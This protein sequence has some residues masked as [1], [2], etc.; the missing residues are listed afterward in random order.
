M[1][2]VSGREWTLLSEKLTPPQRLIELYGKVLAQLLVNRGFEDHHE[3]IFDIRLSAIPSYKHL[4]NIEEGAERIVRA[5]RKKERIII[6]GDYDVDGLTGTAILYEILRRAGA[7]VVPV[8]PS[9]GTGYGLSEKLLRIFSRYGDLLIAV[10]NGS[11]AVSEFDSFPLD[12]IVID[13]HNVPERQRAEAILINPRSSEDSPREMK[14]LSSSAMCFYIATLLVSRLGIDLDT[15]MYLDLVALG[16]VA[17]VMPLNY[18]NRILVSKGTDLL[19]S[20]IEGKVSKPGVRSLLEISRITESVTSKDIAY[21]IAPRL[22]APGR[23]GD[24]KIALDLLTEKNPL[25]AR[26]LSRKIELINHKR[27]AVTGIV[28]KEALKSAELQREESFISLWSPRWHVGVLGIVAGRL[29]RTFGKPVAVLAVGEEKAVGSVRSSE[30]IN[31]YE[32]L[33]K[34]SDLFIKWGGHPHAAGITVPTRDLERFRETAREVFREVPKELPPLQVDLELAPWE[35]TDVI[36]QELKR[37]EPF[38]EGN[39]YP[40]FLSPPAV[41]EEVEIRNGSSR[42]IFGGKEIRCWE[43]NILPYLKRGMRRRI[44]YS[45]MNGELSLVD[46]EANGA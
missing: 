11:S 19:R 28:L 17:D 39:P 42:I 41:I 40:T 7:K 5:V 31:I 36:Q 20:I 12:V 16:T 25:R 1:R 26:L 45:V 46:I 14:E 13:H 23:L 32:G 4:P 10:D 24:P 29:S 22:N 2:G 15:R 27:R 9:R 33:K 6:F 18:L 35:L 37:L 44:V 30:G 38:G 43:E 3:A 34:M 8:L 21:S